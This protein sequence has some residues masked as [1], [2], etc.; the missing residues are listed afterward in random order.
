MSWSLWLWVGVA[1]LLA[2]ASTSKGLMCYHCSNCRHERGT[3][4]MCNYGYDVC[5]KVVI[6]GRV[7]KSCGK[8]QICGFGPHSRG[9]ISSWS[10]LQ[11]LLS[12]VNTDR[13]RLPGGLY[14]SSI[15]CCASDYC[16]SAKGKMPT[17]SLII[18]PLAVYLMQK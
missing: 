3:A 7:E 2:L 18:L 13:L 16:N 10:H 6:V 9:T 12:D 8:Q 14:D 15:M 5:T 17:Y 4:L 11:K 1:G